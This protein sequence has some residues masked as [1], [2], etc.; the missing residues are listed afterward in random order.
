[1]QEEPGAALQPICATGGQAATGDDHVECAG[2][3][4][5][6]PQVCSTLVIATSLHPSACTAAIV[7]TFRPRL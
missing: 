3:C 4:H 6:E 2:M 5:R 1:M 7:V